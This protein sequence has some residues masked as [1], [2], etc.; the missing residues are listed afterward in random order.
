MARLTSRPFP[1]P[2]RILHPLAE[3]RKRPKLCESLGNR[4]RKRIAKLKEAEIK[5]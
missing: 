2:T 1:L 4:N 3:G 5:D